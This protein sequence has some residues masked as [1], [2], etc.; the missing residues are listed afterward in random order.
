[1]E[2]MRS[3]T[4]RLFKSHYSICAEAGL[5]LYG[6]LRS[7]TDRTFQEVR[8]R[9]LREHAPEASR[10]EPPTAGDALANTIA[11][12]LCASASWWA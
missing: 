7:S 4:L 10:V 1:M 8:L 2:A 6:V 11:T 12:P 3:E 9:A 5:P